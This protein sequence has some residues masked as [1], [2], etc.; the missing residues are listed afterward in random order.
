MIIRD[1]K[2]ED[3]KAV[4][5]IFEM[6]WNDADFRKRLSLKLDLCI[7]QT[8]EYFDR[9]YR[10]FVAEDNGEVVGVACFRSV[11]DRMRVYTKTENPAEFYILAAKYKGKGIG[12]ALRLK[13]LEEAKKMGFTEVVLFSPDTHSESWNFHDKMGFERVGEDTAPDGE[14]G[15]IWRK[16][17]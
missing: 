16:I 3:K 17:L 2:K 4:E 13:R 12:T 14:P 5:D 15:L 11:P 9:K 8:Q 7:N 1:L 6:Y 10:F